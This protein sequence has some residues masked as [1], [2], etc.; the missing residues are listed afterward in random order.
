MTILIELI[1]EHGGHDHERADNEKKHIA[2]THDVPLAKI[3][4]YPVLEVR[5][6]KADGTRRRARQ[7]LEVRRAPFTGY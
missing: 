2:A 7:S 1:A 5:G 4:S 3:I 6:R